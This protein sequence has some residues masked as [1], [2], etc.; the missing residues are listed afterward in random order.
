[1]FVLK[2]LELRFL[3]DR[4]VI[5]RDYKDD[6]INGKMNLLTL[7]DNFSYNN[8]F[9][10]NEE[11]HRAIMIE[12]MFHVSLPSQNYKH[13]LCAV[14]YYVNEHKDGN[15]LAD[16]L[17]ESWVVKL[18]FE[19]DMFTDLWLEHGKSMEQRS[20][21]KGA[22]NNPRLRKNRVSLYSKLKARLDVLIG[23]EGELQNDSGNQHYMFSVSGNGIDLVMD[24]K[25][26]SIILCIN[27]PEII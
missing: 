22:A 9:E 7:K 16:Y 13:W 21:L 6:T 14:L 27:Y 15:G 10:D 17:E 18:N 23:T 19:N 11:N 5:R 3:Y 12:S 24:N 26:P 4:F 1:M 25:L 20:L 2:M 8:T